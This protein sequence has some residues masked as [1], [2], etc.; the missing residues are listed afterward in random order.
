MGGFL[1]GFASRLGTRGWIGKDDLEISE[2]RATHR[3][4]EMKSVVLN[5]SPKGDASVTIQSVRYL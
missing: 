2:K 1:F 5:G 3:G 4:N